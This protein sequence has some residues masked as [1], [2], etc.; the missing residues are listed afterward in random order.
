[1]NHNYK[2]LRLYARLT[3][4]LPV[5]ILRDLYSSSNSEDLDSDDAPDDVEFPQEEF[6]I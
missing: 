2:Q 5:D 6:D 1:M 4:G 3:R